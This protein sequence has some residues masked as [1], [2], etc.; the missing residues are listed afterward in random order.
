MKF[1]IEELYFSLFSEA[2][3]SVRLRY[4]FGEEINAERMLFRQTRKTVS[5]SSLPKVPLHKGIN[6]ID[7]SPQREMQ[8]YELEVEASTNFKAYYRE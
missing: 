3:I 5:T 2:S 1:E 8:L 4:S 6:Y 7:N